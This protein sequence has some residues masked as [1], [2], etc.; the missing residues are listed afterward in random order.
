MTFGRK[1]SFFVIPALVLI[2][3][4]VFAFSKLPEK[5]KEAIVSP[6]QPIAK[7]FKDIATSPIQEIAETSLLNEDGEYAIFVKNLK[8]GEIYAYNEEKQFGSASLYKLWVM[9]VTFQKI[10]ENKIREAE[11]VSGDRDKLNE[12]LLIAQPATPSSEPT[13]SLSEE[14]REEK[15]VSYKVSDGIEKMIT[16]SDNYAAL[17]LSSRIGTPSIV[18]FLKDSG[19]EKSNFKIPPQTSAKDIALFFEQVYNG[20][21][22]N[23]AYSQ[24]MIGILKRQELNDRIPKYLPEDIGVAHKTGELDGYKHDAGIVFGNKGDYIIVVMSNTKNSYV[25]VEEIANFSKRVFDYFEGS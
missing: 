2:P 14:Q 1:L 16:A 17:L 7:A 15:E 4:M 22:I 6:I 9:A 25:V 5:E 10:S 20:E 11:V 12:K 3:I 21:I 24:R 8:T 13:P 18:A 19:F 23:K